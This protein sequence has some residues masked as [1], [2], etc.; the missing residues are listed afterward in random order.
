MIGQLD[1]V[2]SL[3]LHHFIS[4]DD[5]NIVNCLEAPLLFLVLF[6]FYHQLCPLFLHF[7]AVMI[8]QLLLLLMQP[9]LSFLFGFAN[10]DIVLQVFDSVLLSANLHQKPLF[11]FLLECSLLCSDALF[12]VADLSFKLIQLE[13]L[14][15]LIVFPLRL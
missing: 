12:E 13:F 5:Q 9:L 1:I 2:L 3:L 6:L 4:L 7:L 10:G 11:R 15:L 8:K 14:Q